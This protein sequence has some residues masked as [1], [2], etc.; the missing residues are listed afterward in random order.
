[1]GEFADRKIVEVINGIKGR[2]HVNDSDRQLVAMVGD[3]YL[4]ANI[5]EFMDGYDG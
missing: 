1:M 4:K 3:D 5:E 2:Q